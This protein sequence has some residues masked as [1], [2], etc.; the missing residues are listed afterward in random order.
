MEGEAISRMQISLLVAENKRNFAKRPDTFPML[1]HHEA[2]AQ[3][4]FPTRP[5][6]LSQT[7]QCDNPVSRAAFRAGRPKWTKSPPP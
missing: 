5:G 7:K 4:D 1:C 2:A 3:S 6:G